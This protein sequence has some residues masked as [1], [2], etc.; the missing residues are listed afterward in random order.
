[1]LFALLASGSTREATA[2]L[3]S[4]AYSTI[5]FEEVMQALG[6]DQE[7]DM[8]QCTLRRTDWEIGRHRCGAIESNAT[9]PLLSD[10]ASLNWVVVAAD[11][12]VHPK[13]LR[14]AR[15]HLTGIQ[16]LDSLSESVLHLEQNT[17]VKLP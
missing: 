16:Q 15:S 10:C 1:M 8:T 5:A 14:H 7:S 9:L 4:I 3:L 12:M 6:F 17:V 2:E 11:K 13:P